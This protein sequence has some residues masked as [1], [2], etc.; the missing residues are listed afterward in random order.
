VS[1]GFDSLAGDPLG[2]FTLEP[3]D[4]TQWTTALRERVAPAPVVAL[5]EGGYRLDLLASGARATVEALA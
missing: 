2:G 4:V 5:L 3:A 1:A